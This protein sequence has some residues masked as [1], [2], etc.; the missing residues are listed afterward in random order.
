MNSP[1]N[2]PSTRIEELLECAE[3]E[4]DG[5]KQRLFLLQTFVTQLDACTRD[6][7]FAI[8]NH[9]VWVA[10]L[11]SRDMLVV[12]L[13]SW[14]KAAWSQ[15]GVI[16]VIQAHHAARLVVGVA[17]TKEPTGY[18]NK[19]RDEAFLRLFPT[20]AKANRRKPIPQD[21]ADLRD[22][23]KQRIEGSGLMTDRNQN[24]AHRFD[25]KNPGATSMLDLD[26]LR[27]VFEYIE[28]VLTDIRLLATGG[29]REFGDVYNGRNGPA[30][31]ELVDIVLHGSLQ[32]MSLVG[33][34]SSACPEG[35]QPAYWWEKREKFYR[36]LHAKHDVEPSTPPYFNKM[37]GQAP[38][39][40]GGAPP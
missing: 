20:A 36:D 29:T 40:R 23:F 30:A 19:C 15:G 10:M 32:R 2:S 17:G 11:D 8:R 38:T 21:V 18:L 39:V 24:R 26:E 22:A 33:G 5:I 25:H 13:A 16:G 35:E 27:C 6:K 3:A 28:R 1:R 9:T 34:W 12:S 31:A 4:I 7:P 14:C 37:D